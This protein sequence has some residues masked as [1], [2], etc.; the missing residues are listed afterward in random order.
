MEDIEKYK[1]AKQRI[2]ELKGLYVHAIIYIVVNIVMVIMNLV[3]SP[4]HYWFY[5]PLLGWGIGLAI[6]AFSVYAK[7][8]IFGAEWEERKI[9]QMM[10][11][12]KL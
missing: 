8:K 5:W 9:R 12:D 1:K 6:H 2:E 11:K 4:D 3:T 7:G 10:E